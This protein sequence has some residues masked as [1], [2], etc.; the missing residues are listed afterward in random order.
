MEGEE[1]VVGEEHLCWVDYQ[2]WVEVVVEVEVEEGEG[3]HE[4]DGQVG[5]VAAEGGGQ[6][7]L[8]EGVEVEYW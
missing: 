2:T 1:E 5:E 6:D 3:Q 7:P 4:T 8:I